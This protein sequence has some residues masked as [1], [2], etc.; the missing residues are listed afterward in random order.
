MQKSAIPEDSS[1]LRIDHVRNIPGLISP[2][3]SPSFRYLMYPRLH[4]SYKR[5]PRQVRIAISFVISGIRAHNH[6]QAIRIDE[7]EFL[8]HDVINHIHGS[9]GRRRVSEHRRRWRTSP[10]L[11]KTARLKGRRLRSWSVSHGDFR[12]QLEA[13]IAK[14]IKLAAPLRIS[15]P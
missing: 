9:R 6:H 15:Q 3:T 8:R 5:L 14:N 2:K 7:L 10:S 11:A 12:R 13:F 4:R 1:R